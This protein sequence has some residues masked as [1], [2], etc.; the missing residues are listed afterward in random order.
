MSTNIKLNNANGA[1]S[2]LV[3]TNPDTN[4]NGRTIDISKVAH[5]VDT[6]ADLRAMTEKPDTVYVT[7]YHIAGDGAFGSHFFNRVDSAGTDN[8]GTIIV[9]NGVTTYYYALQYDGAVNVKWFGANTANSATANT[10]LFNSIFA[11]GL[12]FDGNGESYNIDNTVYIKNYTKVNNISFVNSSTTGYAISLNIPSSHLGTMLENV[13]ITGVNGLELTGSGWDFNIKNCLFTC[14]GTCIYSNPG[15]FTDVLY[16]RCVFNGG[17]TTAY[18]NS[19]DSHDIHFNNCSFDA[20]SSATQTLLDVTTGG[21]NNSF[22]NCSLWSDG[23]KDVVFLVTPST[24]PASYSSTSLYINGGYYEYLPEQNNQIVIAQAQ[25]MG[26]SSTGPYTFNSLTSKPLSNNLCYLDF[27]QWVGGSSVVD[28]GKYFVGQ[29]VFSISLPAN[30]TTTLVYRL[31]NLGLEKANATLNAINFF[32]YSGVSS[33]MAGSE[34]YLEVD[35]YSY[36]PIYTFGSTEKITF[37]NPK[38]A[39]FIH[40][41]VDSATTAYLVYSLK[42]TTASAITVEMLLPNITNQLVNSLT[43]AGKANYSISKTVT[44]T[45]DGTTKVFNVPT[46]FLISATTIKATPIVNSNGK[47]DYIVQNSTSFDICFNTAPASGAWFALL[48]EWG[49]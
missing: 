15:W 39:L 1:S 45:G 34:I 26:F 8:T 22:N 19:N 37:N 49:V 29:K 40:Y 5:Q 48:V 7:G 43:P 28:T 24:T 3:I 47:Y 42:N 46:G 27:G 10:T 11:L 12:S 2:Q 17:F 30:S 18:K 21:Y 6:I 44:F 25:F 4:F 35:P 13:T 14:T 33:D 32:N 23:G 38:P 20:T 41:T 9:P 36:G 16:E 31:D